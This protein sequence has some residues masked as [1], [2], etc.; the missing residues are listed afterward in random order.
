MLERFM[1]FIAIV[2]IVTIIA[3][4]FSPQLFTWHQT[5]ARKIGEEYARK[6][7][8]TSPDLVRAHG[9]KAVAIFALMR[10]RKLS[11]YKALRATRKY[12]DDMYRQVLEKT[13]IELANEKINRYR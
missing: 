10:D 5:E 8:Q 11:D 12:F 6:T 7:F 9:D 13:V 3:A 2:V 1:I 4:I